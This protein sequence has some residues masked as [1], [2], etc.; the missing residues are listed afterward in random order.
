LQLKFSQDDVQRLQATLDEVKADTLEAKPLSVGT[1]ATARE[2][3]GVAK[4]RLNDLIEQAEIRDGMQ[5]PDTVREASALGVEVYRIALY[6]L[7]FVR[8][9]QLAE[10]RARLRQLAL[11]DTLD[12]YWDGGESVQRMV[13]ILK[14]ARASLAAAID[15]QPH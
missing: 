15:A 3:L 12:M 1:R 7:G 13:E 10:F 14:R 6:P 5:V 2:D 4:N 9:Q 11:V 8:D